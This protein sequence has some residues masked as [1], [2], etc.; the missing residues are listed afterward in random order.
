MESLDDEIR[1][2][3]PKFYDYLP[4]QEIVMTAPQLLSGSYFVERKDLEPDN[5]HIAEYW[6]QLPPKEILQAKL[7]KARI[8]FRREGYGD[9]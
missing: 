9:E 8:A 6:L 1:Q 4:D 7:H 2:R 5:L 3:M